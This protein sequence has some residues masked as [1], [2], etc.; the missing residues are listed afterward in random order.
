VRRILIVDDEPAVREAIAMILTD[1][2]YAVLIAPDGRTALEMIVAAPDLL[3]TDLMMPELDGWG[4]LDH[5]RK[6]YPTLP[7]ILMSAV[8]PIR[9]R[10]VSPPAFDHTVFLSKPFDLE[11]LLATVRQLTGHR[12]A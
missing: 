10:G 9:W 5:V 12:E 8:D 7:V 6:Q 2:G 4:L 11:T 3:I 1:E